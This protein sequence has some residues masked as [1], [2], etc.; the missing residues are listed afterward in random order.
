MEAAEWGYGHC[1]AGAGSGLPFTQE[2]DR[3]IDDHHAFRK[4]D[5]R[6]DVDGRDPVAGLR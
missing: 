5:G 1:G 3:R 4:S 2:F 6:I